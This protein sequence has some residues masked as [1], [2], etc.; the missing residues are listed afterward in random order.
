[1]AKAR[2]RRKNRGGRF[3][4]L[5]LLAAVF[6]AAYMYVFRVRTLRVEGVKPIG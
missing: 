4:A 1:M 3:L 5:L 6:I 2:K